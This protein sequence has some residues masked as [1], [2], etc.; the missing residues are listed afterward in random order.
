MWRRRWYVELCWPWFELGLRTLEI[1]LF[2]FL[3]FLRHEANQAN[4]KCIK[5]QRKRAHHEGRPGPSD[6][7]HRHVKSNTNRTPPQTTPWTH[8]TKDNLHATILL[9][10]EL[11]HL[12]NYVVA[13]N[14][15]R[16]S[17]CS[18]YKGH[19]LA[20][21]VWLKPWSI[22]GAEK[23]LILIC[24]TLFS[25]CWKQIIRVVPMP[26]WYKWWVQPKFDVWP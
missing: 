10:K 6:A 18:S 1:H 8:L 3:F 17:N 25:S 11:N 15:T 7:K 12:T 5:K 13:S 23:L 26:P 4:T 2:H 22:A 24:L 20:P 9:S 19:F 21:H 16:Y 14:F